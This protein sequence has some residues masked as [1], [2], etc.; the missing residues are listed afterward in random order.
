MSVSASGPSQAIQSKPDTQRYADRKDGSAKQRR[1]WTKDIDDDIIR[2]HN[3]G[4]PWKMIDEKLGR[5]HSSCHHRY[6][7][8]LDPNL[9]AWNL[10]NSLPDTAMLERLVYLVDIEKQ[11]FE[12]IRD[13]MLMNKPWK[14]PTK[15]APQEVL[16]GAA[17]ETLPK[18]VTKSNPFSESTRKNEETPYVLF[19]KVTLMNKYN[20]Y[21]NRQAR[22]VLRANEELFHKAIRRSVELYG[23]NWKKVAMN[24]DELLGYW[25]PSTVWKPVTPAKVASKYKVLQRNGVEWSLEDDAVMVRKILQLGKERPDI[26]DI[27]A[28]TLREKA[29]D[30]ERERQQEQQRQLWTEISIALGNHSPE[31]CKRRWSGLWRLNDNEKSAQSK[32]WHRF[33]RYQFWMLWKHFSQHYPLE[34]IVPN[35]PLTTTQDLD[36]A[37]DEL[38]F[39]KEITKWMRHRS[40]AQCLKHF[41][42]AVN[43]NLRLGIAPKEQDQQ[44]SRQQAQQQV[45]AGKD[46]AVEVRKAETKAS[47]VDS[48]LS[49]VAEPFLLKVSTVF[50]ANEQSM[51]DDDH[52]PIVR[53]DWTKEQIR[54]LHEIVMRE[55]QGVK[56]A[57]FELNWTRIAK[58]MES[59]FRATGTVAS[60]VEDST[61]VD[62]QQQQLKVIFKPEQCQRCWAYISSPGS[63]ALSVLTLAKTAAESEGDAKDEATGGDHRPFSHVQGW[64]DHELLLLQQGV[65]KYGTLWADVRAQFLPNRDISDIYRVWLSI[66]APASAG[67]GRDGDNGQVV[68]DRLSEPDYVGL[69]SAL[70]KVGG[71]AAG[72]GSPGGNRP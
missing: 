28:R 19:S 57:D 72:E 44:Q 9:E 39:S 8:T 71:K 27:L 11:S 7:S 35:A 23:E 47:L 42:S 14:T 65:R 48:I 63:S 12:Q 45:Q 15:F 38:S 62:A 37:C 36:A 26:L 25:M 20:E 59:E 64:S 13:R 22:N 3:E 58:R 40:E 32:S 60:I 50:Y 51:R 70:D 56:R 10:P 34:G 31:Q 46:E 61:M 41:K 69:L 55:K 54:A 49:Q 2:L 66:S 17:Q 53:S 5:P 24:V 18:Y 67:E 21:K 33:E 30:P 6:Y 43:S 1:K 68:T 16:D 29:S 4:V 52:Q